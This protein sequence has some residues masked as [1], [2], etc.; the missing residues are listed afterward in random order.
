ME[1][2]RLLHDIYSEDINGHIYRGYT[3]LPP[4]KIVETPLRE[5]V[6]YSGAKKPVWFVF[7]GMGS[8]WPGMGMKFSSDVLMCLYIAWYVHKFILILRS[9]IKEKH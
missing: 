3:V 1:Y 6:N 8:Q 5:I 4:T 2:V 9:V 7:S